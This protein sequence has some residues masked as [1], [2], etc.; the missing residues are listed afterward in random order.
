M[1]VWTAESQC[2]LDTTDVEGQRAKAIQ[3]IPRDV[4]TDVLETM[5]RLQES[6]MTY[7][8]L[9]DGLSIIGSY[10]GNERCPRVAGLHVRNHGGLHVLLRVVPASRILR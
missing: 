6:R 3:L 10:G 8:G 7:A 5:V 1:Y 4:W 2:R 9:T